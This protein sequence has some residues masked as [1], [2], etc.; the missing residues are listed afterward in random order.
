M[1]GFFMA[2]GMF[3]AIP[4]PRKV[5]DSEKYP[6][7]LL[8][9][10]LIGLMLG[11]LWA[12]AGLLAV[13]LGFLGAALMAVLPALLSGFIHLDGYMDCADAVLSRRELEKRRAILKDSHVGAF[14]VIAFGLWL[15]LGF[16]AFASLDLEKALFTLPF[17]PAVCRGCSAT[18]VLSFAMGETMVFAVLAVLVGGVSGCAAVFGA[19]G[20]WAAIHALRKDLQGMSGDISGCAITVGELCA[21]MALVILS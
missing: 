18:A 15:L 13:K 20:S 12:L 2:W 8:S 4:C 21:V 19:L 3:C 10:P 14:A 1:T 17:I 9:L 16:A 6:R 7:M 11:L 5:W